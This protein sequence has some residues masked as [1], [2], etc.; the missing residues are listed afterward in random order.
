MLTGRI[1][2]L[3]YWLKKLFSRK[4]PETSA[5][6]PSKPTPSGMAEK[7]CSNSG[8]TISFDP[9][10]THIPNYC[11]ECKAKYRAEHPQKGSRK[12]IRRQCRSCGRERVYLPIDCSALAKLLPGLPGEV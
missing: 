6:V 9:S 10:W 1:H 4:E 12:L 11:P 7:P 2:S 3:F 5:P 8:K